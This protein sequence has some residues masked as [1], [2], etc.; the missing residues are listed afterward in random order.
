MLLET[1]IVPWVLFVGFCTQEK[2][3]FPVVMCMNA[4]Y[5]NY[6][7]DMHK[8]KSNTYDIYLRIQRLKVVGMK[9][10]RGQALGIT[11]ATIIR[12][13][14]IYHSGPVFFLFIYNKHGCKQQQD[15]IFSI[16]IICDVL[17]SLIL[18]FRS[19][20]CIYHQKR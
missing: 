19:F 2:I 1:Q 18:P 12:V 20:M 11:S 10:E 4:L 6:L 7:F 8:I 15:A 16:T 3:E 14:Y 17:L 9:M 13:T 5:W